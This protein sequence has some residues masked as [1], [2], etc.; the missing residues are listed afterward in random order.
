MGLSRLACLEDRQLVRIVF[1]HDTGR[2]CKEQTS[3]Y[4]DRSRESGETLGFRTERD[5]DL[6][7]FTMNTR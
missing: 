6:A 7:K 5:N 3:I 1:F 4:S 2:V